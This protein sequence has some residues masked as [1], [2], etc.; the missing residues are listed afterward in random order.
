MVTISEIMEGNK[1]KALRCH[2]IAQKHRKLH[3]GQE[4]HSTLMTKGTEEATRATKTEKH[5]SAGGTHHWH[6]NRNA[7]TNGSA[8]GSSSGSNKNGA[9]GADEGFKSAFLCAIGFRFD[10]L[11]CIQTQTQSFLLGY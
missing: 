6:P 10:G 9:P 1:D 8:E 11:T 3:L 4:V 2:L 7:S 5:P